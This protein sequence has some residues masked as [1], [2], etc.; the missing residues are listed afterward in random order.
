MIPL[1]EAEV[2]IAQDVILN[3][4]DNAEARFV[5]DETCGV[6]EIHYPGEIL[7]DGQTAAEWSF[8]HHFAGPP[9]IIKAEH[10]KKLR[11]GIDDYMRLPVQFRDAG[12]I[13]KLPFDLVIWPV[14]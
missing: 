14:D 9:Y 6:Q 13:A 7:S 8:E 2:T 4:A 10:I 1:R 11:L 5:P 3:N 12:G